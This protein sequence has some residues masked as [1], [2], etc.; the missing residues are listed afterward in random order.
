MLINNIIKVKLIKNN[1]C[2]E[3]FRNK[4]RNFNLSIN[5]ILLLDWQWN[6]TIQNYGILNCK[7]LEFHLH[8]LNIKHPIIPQILSTL[9]SLFK[10]YLLKSY[11]PG[12]ALHSGNTQGT[13]ETKICPLC[14][15]H[16][17]QGRREEQTQNK[18]YI[19]R[20]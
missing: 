14:N 13:K 18:L 6:T 15:F 3:L 17:K 1:P 12:I 4:F 16:F 9:Y 19:T 8:Q 10:K 5:L 2:L 11:Y 7:H 20:W